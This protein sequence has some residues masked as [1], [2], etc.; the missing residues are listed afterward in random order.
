[1]SLERLSKDVSSKVSV[2]YLQLEDIFEELTDIDCQN[3]ALVSA[4]SSLEITLN[5]L[6]KTLSKRLS[7]PSS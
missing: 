7:T 2:L 5:L 4:I 3:D 1:M 6:D